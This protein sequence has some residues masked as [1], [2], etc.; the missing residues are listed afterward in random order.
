M[1]ILKCRSNFKISYTCS[2]RQQRYVKKTNTVDKKTFKSNFKQ[3]SSFPFS[4]RP[5]IKA[6]PFDGY[7]ILYDTQNKMT[8]SGRR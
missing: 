4:V 8:D 2:G 5:L 7:I 1:R 3:R 6:V